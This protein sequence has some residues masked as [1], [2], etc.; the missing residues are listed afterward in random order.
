MGGPEQTQRYVR[1]RVPRETAHLPQMAEFDEV[2]KALAEGI[3]PDSRAIDTLTRSRRH[4]DVGRV[5]LPRPFKIVR[6]G[7]VR[8]FV[9]DVDRSTE[10]YQRVLGFTL[11][12]ETL[13]D[14][15]AAHSCA[16]TL[17]TTRWRS[18]RNSCALR[19]GAR[20]RTQR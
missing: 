13:F 11:T 7:P 15:R 16:A 2:Q 3:A 19:W 6:I 10:F 20:A 8:L 9:N 1:P 5:L 18:T 4:I 14:G 12:E 17:S